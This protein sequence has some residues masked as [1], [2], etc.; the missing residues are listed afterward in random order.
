[1][2]PKYNNFYVNGVDELI[3]FV[4]T[5]QFETNPY[6]YYWWVI[7]FGI[8]ANFIGTNNIILSLC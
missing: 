2:I 4:Y 3:K 8:K 7:L 5:L 1:M 6:K